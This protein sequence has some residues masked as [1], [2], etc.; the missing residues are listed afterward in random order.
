[1]LHFSTPKYELD[2]DIFLRGKKHSFH[3]NWMRFSTKKLSILVGLGK[4]TPFHPEQRRWTNFLEMLFN[5]V[6]HSLF[7]WFGYEERRVGEQG[8]A[9]I[10]ERLKY[11]QNSQG[12][13]TKR[14][15]RNKYQKIIYILGTK[16]TIWYGAG[17][18][19]TPASPPHHMACLA[20]LDPTL[21]GVLFLSYLFH[22]QKSC[23]NIPII[24]SAYSINN[25]ALKKISTSS[26]PR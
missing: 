5:V 12:H 18:H 26:F 15:R 6:V 11:S 3:V 22:R 21:G 16:M 24:V 25:R 17:I 13:W 4:F 1:M 23:F 2:P 20:F 7:S 9:P 19:I 10:M 8:E 14:A